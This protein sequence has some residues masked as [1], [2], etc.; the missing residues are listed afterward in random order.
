MC[1]AGGKPAEDARCLGYYEFLKDLG[2][3]GGFKADATA[4]HYRWIAGRG[5]P[6]IAAA[7]VFDRRGAAAYLPGLPH[8]VETTEALA[9]HVEGLACPVKAADHHVGCHV[10]VPIASLL[11]WMASRWKTVLWPL[12]ARKTCH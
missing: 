7:Y 4:F 9:T 12:C 10:T 5:C 8:P 3:A 1:G 2:K 6:R 11:I